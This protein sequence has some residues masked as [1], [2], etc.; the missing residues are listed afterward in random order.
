MI[1]NVSAQTLGPE[2][3]TNGDFS[4][5]RPEN[6]SLP[7]E[8]VFCFDVGT[9]ICLSDSL[10]IPNVNLSGGLLRINQTNQVQND[11]VGHNQSLSLS[12]AKEYQLEIRYKTNGKSFIQIGRRA[13]LG[14]SNNCFDGIYNSSGIFAEPFQ[15][16]IFPFNSINN[17]ID[18]NEFVISTLKI[19]NENMILDNYTI[20]VGFPDLTMNPN[21][22]YIHINYISLREILPEEP[23][24][25][26]NN[27]NSIFV[28]DSY[29]SLFLDIS[30]LAGLIT[31]MVRPAS[32]SIYDLGTQALRWRNIYTL[33]LDASGNI[34]TNMLV[35]TTI[36]EN[37]NRF[38]QPTSCS[39][40][41]KISAFLSN[42]QFTCSSDLDTIGNITKTT[43]C[44]ASTC[45]V[46]VSA[47]SQVSIW[48]KGSVT[49]TNNQNTISL[50]VNSTALDSITFKQAANQDRIPFSLLALHK[51][52]QTG[53]INVSITTTGGTLNDLG[54][55]VQ[56][57]N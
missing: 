33:N 40:T 42:G 11:F 10:A 25:W 1:P 31:N 50:S 6:S 57:V 30:N 21:G 29:S 46:P 5:T 22:T 26:F 27:S 13:D 54:I 37:N 23:V 53:N 32:D 49:G 14:D 36:F 9:A 20:V 48:A 38:P 34:S 15:P 41:D 52:T 44:S 55:M 19:S 12:G 51:P 35:G 24:T 4:Q 18:G 28:N 7:K 8:W 45:V 2:I 3:L 16:C 17:T 56:V 39:G 47:N 43:F